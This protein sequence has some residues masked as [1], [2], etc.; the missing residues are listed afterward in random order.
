MKIYTKTIDN[1][2]VVMSA[3]NIIIHKGG[4]QTINPTEEMILADG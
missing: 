1:R 2:Q 3:N 4:F